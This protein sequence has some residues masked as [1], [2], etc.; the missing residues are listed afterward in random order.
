MALDVDNVSGALQKA[1]T[2]MTRILEEAKQRAEHDRH[3]LG[4]FNFDID[5]VMN[6]KHS[7]NSIRVPL[8]PTRHCLLLD[9]SVKCRGASASYL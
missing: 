1:A 6:T 3:G 9:L 2:E 7:E 4:F 8:L 5:T